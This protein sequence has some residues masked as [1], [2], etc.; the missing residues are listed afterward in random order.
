MISTT[1]QGG[2][3]YRREDKCRHCGEHLGW[4]M[5]PIGEMLALGCCDKKECRKK[6]R[7]MREDN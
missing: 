1:E 6:E 5:D 4:I 2:G 3:A 7:K